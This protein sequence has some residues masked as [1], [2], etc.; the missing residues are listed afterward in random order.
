[1]SELFIPI[2]PWIKERRERSENEMQ[3]Y[4]LKCRK[5]GIRFIGYCLPTKC[6]ICGSGDID[7]NT[8]SLYRF[9]NEKQSHGR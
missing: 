9:A 8:P 6:P 4:V 5:C 2:P 3:N 7:E 1:M